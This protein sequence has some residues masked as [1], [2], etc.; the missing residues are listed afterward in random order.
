M[1]NST[2]LIFIGLPVYWIMVV[3]YIAIIIFLMIMASI[4]LMPIAHIIL[5]LIIPVVIISLTFLTIKGIKYNKEIS[6]QFKLDLSPLIKI[7]LK[8]WP[9]YGIIVAFE[10]ILS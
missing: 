4:I 10:N 5:L 8:V 6:K 7:L 3:L 1:I 9:Y 2:K